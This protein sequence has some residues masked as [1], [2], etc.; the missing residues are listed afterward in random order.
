MVAYL[1][2]RVVGGMVTLVLS[3]LI[4]YSLVLYLPRGVLESKTRNYS[5]A[6][7]VPLLTKLWISKSY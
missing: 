2:R 5:V 3:G 7:L 1:A 6:L 4:L